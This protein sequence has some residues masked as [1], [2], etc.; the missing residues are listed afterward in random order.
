MDGARALRHA[1]GVR[2][3]PGRLVLLFSLGSLGSLGASFVLACTTL[4]AA[5]DTTPPPGEDDAGDEAARDASASRDGSADAAAAQPDAGAPADASAQGACT[6]ATC[7]PEVLLENLFGPISLAL[8]AT[9]FYW[10]E[11][12]SKIPNGGGQAQLVRL[13][14]TTTCKL[15]GCFDVLDYFLVSGEL[16]GQ[17]I[18]GT[19]VEAAAS[20]V[21]VTQ[22][23]NASPQHAI[24]CYAKPNLAARSLDQAAGEVRALWVSATSARWVLASTTGTSNDGALQGRP[25]DAGATRTLAGSRP[26]PTGLTSDGA[27]VFWTERGAVTGQGA[28]LTVGPDAGP[29]PFATGVGTP[30]SPRIFGEH[31][32]WIDAA[33][34]K[35]VRKRLDG[36]D[37]AIALAATD[38]GPFELA[39]D[40]SGVYWACAGGGQSG[41]NGSLSHVSTAGGQTTTMLSGLVN[42]AD[43]ALDG[44]HLYWATLGAAP[45]D[46]GRITRIKKT[47]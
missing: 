19:Q 30:T 23:Y 42:L 8:D 41:V 35:I 27:A 31:L 38:V 18:Y 26:G 12:G 15:R 40:A 46:K 11:V 21:C 44:T 7:P 5:D 45:F 43:L 10:A 34:R 2:R 6:Q 32:Y 37:A 20:D 39:V 13:P 36:T 25:L 14:K 16:E 17:L 3:I 29:A 22:S 1:S 33:G 24:K 4:K 9:H 28:V 47:P